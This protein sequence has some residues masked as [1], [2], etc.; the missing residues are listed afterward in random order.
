MID[1]AGPKAPAA[2]S[3]PPL[4]DR[5]SLTR[6]TVIAVLLLLA[7]FALPPLMSGY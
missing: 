2:S 5:R 7:I 1:T 6:A 4:L 3:R